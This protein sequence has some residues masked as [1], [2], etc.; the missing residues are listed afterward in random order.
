M[1]INVDLFYFGSI[2]LLAQVI[3]SNWEGALWK[4]SSP[5]RPQK[6]KCLYCKHR[7]MADERAGGE[8]NINDNM[9]NQLQL[10]PG[11]S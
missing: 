6:K 8:D 9:G 11:D 3:L 4:R 1:S 5:S 10:L 7:D 2:L